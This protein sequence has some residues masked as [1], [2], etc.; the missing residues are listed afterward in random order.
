MGVG[1]FFQKLAPWLS[2][3]VQFVPGAGPAIAGV[4]TKIAGDHGVSLPSAVEPT[5]ES[6]GNAVAAMTGNSAAMAALKK[7]DQDYALQMQA[8][9]FK[10]VDDLIALGNED[11]ASA[12]NR[13]IQVKDNTP[14]ILAYL[15]AAGFFI[16]LAAEI[17]IAVSGKTVNPLAEKSIDL[18]LGVLVGMVLGTKE[19]YFGS[20]AG[21]DKKSDLLADIAKQP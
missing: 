4:I 2:A 21:S 3:G 8:A 5:V 18:L 9:G 13:E 10:Q 16:T 11:R 15:Y 7:Q 19:Y 1:S 20:S 17:W 6:I 12:R 14:K